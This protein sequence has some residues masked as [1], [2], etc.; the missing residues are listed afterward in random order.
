MNKKD[1]KRSEL[2]VEK[3]AEQQTFASTDEIQVPANMADR[4][5]GQ[6]EAVEVMRKAAYD[7]LA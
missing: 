4:V 6:D 3:W 7:M 1:V 5:I 2:S